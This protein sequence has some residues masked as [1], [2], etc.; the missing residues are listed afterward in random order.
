MPSCKVL[1]ET[2]IRIGMGKVVHHAPLVHVQ[3]YGTLL[4][5]KWGSV[6]GVE[7]R[8]EKAD[9]TRYRPSQRWEEYGRFRMDFALSAPP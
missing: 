9:A 1:P 4:S 3:A 6:P 5:E 7:L 2:R 8:E